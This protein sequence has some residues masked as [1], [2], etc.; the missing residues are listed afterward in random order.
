[1]RRRG[2]AAVHL[3]G[4]VHGAEHVEG[5]VGEDEGERE[6]IA[7]VLVVADETAEQDGDKQEFPAVGIAQEPGQHG[8]DDEGGHEP[9]DVHAVD[10]ME[11]KAVADKI[12]ECENLYEDELTAKHAKWVEKFILEYDD[13][14]GDNIDKIIQTEVGRTFI[15]MLE[16]SAV[17]KHNPEGQ[18]GLEKFI[19]SL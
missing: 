16:S 2:D 11:L 3:G 6:E 17:F 12:L 19:Q 7:D 10:Q 14:S 5:P 8:M 18:E 15:E 4:V 1:M 13:I 9:G